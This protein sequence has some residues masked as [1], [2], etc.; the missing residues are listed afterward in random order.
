VVVCNFVLRHDEVWST[1][2]G[3]GESEAAQWSDNVNTQ[4]VQS[5]V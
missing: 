1:G 4:L 5:G 2:A 3:R